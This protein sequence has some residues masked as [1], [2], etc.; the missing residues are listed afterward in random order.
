[1]FARVTTFDGPP[2]QVGAAMANFRE[3]VVPRL[4]EATGFRG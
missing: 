2:G 1:M 3:E 4:R